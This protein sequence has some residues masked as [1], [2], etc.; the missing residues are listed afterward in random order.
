MIRVLQY[1]YQVPGTRYL[2]PV[3]YISWEPAGRP[4]AAATINPSRACVVRGLRGRRRRATHL[5]YE[6]CTVQYLYSTVLYSTVQVRII[7]VN[8]NWL[9][10]TTTMA[11]C[12]ASRR[13]THTNRA[14]PFSFLIHPFYTTNTM[15][16]QSNASRTTKQSLSSLSCSSETDPTIRQAS[17]TSFFTAQPRR[18]DSSFRKR[19]MCSIKPTVS[20]ETRM[21]DSGEPL[22]HSHVEIPAPTM[23]TC[24]PNLASKSIPK[25]SKS[26]QQ[27]YLDFGQKSFGEQTLCLT[28][29][30]LYDA[31]LDEDSQQHK[32]VCADY[33]HGVPFQAASARVVV[34][35]NTSTSIIEVIIVSTTVYW[36]LRSSFLMY[37]YLTSLC[38]YPTGS[39]K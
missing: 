20:Q 2:V 37:S 7:T 10:T 21:L 18:N 11:A 19:K 15:R 22:P 24:V 29:G 27:M 1:S 26:L 34:S 31:R 4:R 23:T 36:D 6:Y 14:R 3:Q 9:L 8:N 25:T 35:I 5:L 30:M 33:I 16:R 13:I 17:I 28:C 32:R 38:D 39:S 12:A